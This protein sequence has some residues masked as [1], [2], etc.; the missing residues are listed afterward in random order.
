[1]EAI[2]YQGKINIS[3]NDQGKIVYELPYKISEQF[4]S[5]F[6][7][8]DEKKEHYGIKGYSVRSSTLEEVF[9]TLGEMEKEAEKKEGEKIIDNAERDNLEQFVPEVQ[10]L[11]FCA[12]FSASFSLHFRSSFL[13]GYV[14]MF[15]LSIAMFTLAA[16]L[17]YFALINKNI[18]INYTDMGSIY[19]TVTPMDVYYNDMTEAGTTNA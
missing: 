8:I 10:E 2:E 6:A 15:I 16:L 4:S 1:M 12:L 9:I 17:T 5:L 14:C 11:G 13:I 18:S 3:K 19:S 7:E